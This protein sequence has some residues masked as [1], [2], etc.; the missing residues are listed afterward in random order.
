MFEALAQPFSNPPPQ[1]MQNI[2]N[3]HPGP[4]VTAQPKKIAETNPVHDE[5]NFQLV[6]LFPDMEN[7]PLNDDNFL[8]AINKIEQENSQL[9]PSMPQNQLVVNNTV[10]APPAVPTTCINTQQ[11]TSNVVKN[12][13]NPNV[14]MPHMFF[15]N[16]NVTINYNF[17]AK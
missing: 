4:Q 15:P 2:G 11:I 17:N 12:I 3:I 13:N 5:Q 1:P 8:A 7:D 9:V 10:P 16:S 14:P 6:D